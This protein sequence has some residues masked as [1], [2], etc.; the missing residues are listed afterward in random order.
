MQNM[1]NSPSRAALARDWPLH[2]GSGAPARYGAP[3]ACN[4]VG[5]RTLPLSMALGAF[6][7]ADWDAPLQC[8]PWQVAGANATFAQMAAVHSFLLPFFQS[9]D[10]PFALCRAPSSLSMC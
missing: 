3:R 1:A 6:P 9:R 8:P 4:C 2:H 10:R 7:K 5:C